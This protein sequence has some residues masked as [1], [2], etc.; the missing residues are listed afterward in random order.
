MSTFD[1]PRRQNLGGFI[2]D[3]TSR[4]RALE[5]A[6]PDVPLAAILVN[7]TVAPVAGDY[8]EFPADDD[9]VGTHLIR[10]KVFCSTAG[11]GTTT[12]MISNETAGVN[13]LTTALVIPSGERVSGAESIDVDNDLVVNV[14]DF[15]RITLVT[16]AAGV[17]GFGFSL[18]FGFA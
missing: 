2:N 1:V 18:R 15:I 12:A 9:Y 10:A 3:Q 11:G 6:A 16:V 17:L 7:P 5:Q 13:M 8:W 4:V 14:N